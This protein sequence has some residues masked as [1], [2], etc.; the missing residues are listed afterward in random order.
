[1]VNHPTEKDGD[2]SFEDGHLMI[3]RAMDYGDDVISDEEGSVVSNGDDCEAKTYYISKANDPKV[4]FAMAIGTKNKDGKQCITC[5]HKVF[6]NAKKSIKPAN[7][8]LIA[9]QER[10]RT[11]NGLTQI[12]L[13]KQTVRAKLI[14][15]LGQYPITNDRDITW[16]FA[17]LK[18]FYEKAYSVT[19]KS[20]SAN[21]NGTG[22]WQGHAPYVRLLHATL[23]VAR[24]KK[25]FI[26]SFDVMS[27]KQLDGRSN[28]EVAKVDPWSL[29]TGTYNA[30]TFNLT[31][32]DYR[33][34]HPDLGD[35]LD[36]S[37]K[38]VVEVMGKITPEKAKSKYTEMKNSGTIVKARFEAS[39]RGDGSYDPTGRDFAD[40]NHDVPVGG[41]GSWVACLRTGGLHVLYF[42]KYV[43][44]HGVE[45]QA[46]QKFKE[47]YR[48]EG[49]VVPSQ[50]KK[51]KQSNIQSDETVIDNLRKAVQSSA[52]MANMSIIM[53]NKSVIRKKTEI[54]KIRRMIQRMKVNNENEATIALEEE[55][56]AE[57][58][59]DLSSLQSEL[60]LEKQ[61][62]AVTYNSSSVG[63]H[64]EDSGAATERTERSEPDIM[65]D[66][67]WT[68]NNEN[69]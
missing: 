11:Q 15:Q 43:Q 32:S 29:I 42:I 35:I 44:E 12:K 5:D 16:I 33:N 45:A 54:R 24:N 6:R 61:R 63:V 18:L 13:N 14:E 30:D 65:E 25:A 50:A 53:I 19:T 10:R 55:L 47:G 36:I 46:Y 1:M 62:Y 27:K 59:S 67:N 49:N 23:D 28:P 48:L 40:D 58:S 56:L 26:E 8:N 4:L 69:M 17:E 64:N 37:Y 38:T 9:E 2:E 20:A 41:D 57:E 68:D 60:E 34:M 7:T 39:R 52:E 51:R 22:R 3:S 31:A 21:A 66:A